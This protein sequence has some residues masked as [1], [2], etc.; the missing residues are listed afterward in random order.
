[1]RPSRYKSGIPGKRC[2]PSLQETRCRGR[3]KDNWQAPGGAWQNKRGSGA[4]E[5]LGRAAGKAILPGNA[6]PTPQ[7]A[8]ETDGRRRHNRHGAQEGRGG[9]RDADDWEWTIHPGTSSGEPEGRLL[10]NKTG[11]S[12]CQS[13]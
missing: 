7:L 12:W 11:T 3:P 1:M 2:A 5:A 6:R 4:E 8:W 10:S 9:G 13:Y